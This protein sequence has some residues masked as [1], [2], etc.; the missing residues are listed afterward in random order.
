MSVLQERLLDKLKTAAPPFSKRGSKQA[1]LNHF[2]VFKDDDD[3]EEQ[4][5]NLRAQREAT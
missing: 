1:V 5:A 3:L 2:G 4:L